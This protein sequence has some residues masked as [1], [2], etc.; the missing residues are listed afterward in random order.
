MIV[1]DMCMIC[2]PKKK[3]GNKLENYLIKREMILLI[4]VLFFSIPISNL[5]AKDWKIPENHRLERIICKQVGKKQLTD[6][7]LQE[8][9]EIYINAKYGSCNKLDG[10][11]KLPNL[12]A[13]IL[14]PGTITD[15]NAII[16]LKNLTYISIH[17]N[18]IKSYKPLD[19]CTNLEGIDLSYL[20][21]VDL[22]YLQNL[23]SLKKIYLIDCGLDSIDELKNL[24]P[25]EVYLWEN[26]ISSLPD[27]SSWTNIKKLN[28]AGNPVAKETRIVDENGYVR[29]NYFN[30]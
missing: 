25:I 27:L 16:K 20:K 29:M 4:S 13:I 6:L 14:D 12:T 24:N 17:R 22:S 19:E 7:D 18:P 10:I 2:L 28:V 5:S 11:E 23:S 3:D 1:K 9:T 30:K 15:L 21:K 8:V 26:N